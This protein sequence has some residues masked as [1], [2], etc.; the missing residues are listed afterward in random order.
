MVAMA[1]DDVY[2]RIEADLRAG[3]TFMAANRL[4]SLAAADPGNLEI[5]AR[6]ATLYRSVGDRVSAGRW[7]FLT[8]TATSEEIAAFE[9]VQQSPGTR[10]RMLRL[11][12]DPTAGL[13]PIAAG[14]MAALR[15]AAEDEGPISWHWEKPRTRTG[16]LDVLL[17]LGCLLVVLTIVAL[18]IF[19]AT[20]L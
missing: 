12:A 7:G 17:P 1:G 4:A 5:R 10:L 11:P 20:Q 15:A 3:H 18:A 6:R 16:V 8:E 2:E 9:R 14:R 13:G 19:G